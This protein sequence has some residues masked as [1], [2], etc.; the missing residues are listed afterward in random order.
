MPAERAAFLPVS[1]EAMAQHQQLHDPN[2]Y[3]DIRWPRDSGQGTEYASSSE[4]SRDLSPTD[5]A[6]GRQKEEQYRKAGA[7]DDDDEDQQ[8]LPSRQRFLDSRFAH[9]FVKR[10]LPGLFSQRALKVL[11]AVYDG[12]DRTIF[13]PGF[14][15]LATGGVTFAGIFVSC[16]LIVDF[17]V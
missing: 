7:G 10:R 11:E 12:I 14:I 13:I 4:H 1:I 5:A 16:N 2:G 6:Q 3:R 8:E 17:H 15:A 9:G